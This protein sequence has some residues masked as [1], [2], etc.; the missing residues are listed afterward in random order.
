M[1]SLE[2]AS[3]HGARCFS[4]DSSVALA[5]CSYMYAMHMD[6]SDKNLMQSSRTF[7]R[8]DMIIP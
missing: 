3:D 1:L 4:L 5:M 7:A 2:Q 6:Q 8:F